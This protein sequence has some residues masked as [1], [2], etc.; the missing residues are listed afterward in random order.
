MLRRVSVLV[1]CATLAA[2]YAHAVPPQDLKLAEVK[3]WGLADGLPEESISCITESPDG[4]I[5][6]ATREGLVRFNGQ[7]F[8]Q[9]SPGQAAGQYD[10][11]LGAV[12]ATADVLWAGGRDY[13]GFALADDYRSFTRLKFKSTPFPRAGS[14][15]YGVVTMQS[16]PDG[17]VLL[18]RS[19]GV[20]SV[21]GR[22]HGGS[23][24]PQLIAAPPHGES[25]LGYREGRSG[26]WAVTRSGLKRWN[27]REWLPLRPAPDAPSSILEARDGSL[28]IYSDAELVHISGN[29]TRTYKLT[30]SLIGQ[31]A[32]SLIEDRDGAIWAGS[33]GYA[34]RI[35]GGNVER[36]DLGAHLRNDDLV[37]T[38]FQA[39]DGSVWMGSRTGVLLRVDAPVFS[40]VGRE[41]GV[42]AASA[43]AVQQDRTGRMWIGTRT[44]G[45]FVQAGDRWNKLPGSEERI[46]HAIAPLRDG[47]VMGADSNGLWVSNGTVLTELFNRPDRALGGFRALSA[48]YGDHI[49]ISDPAGVYR[50]P[51][52]TGSPIR[53][54]SSVGATR[55]LTELEDGVWGVSWDRGVFRIRDGV[56][57]EYPLRDISAS[58]GMTLLSL[59]PR[60]FLIGT[61]N[62]VFGFDRTT[63]T[64]IKAKTLLAG[65]QVFFIQEDGDG[66]LWFAGRRSLVWAAKTAVAAWFEGTGGPVPPTRLT[67]SQGLASTNYGLGTSSVAMLASDGQLWL[68]SQAG[69]IHFNPASV[70]SARPDVRCAI[71]EVLIDGAAVPL[72]GAI[73]VKPGAKRLQIRYTVLG[74]RAAENPAFRYRLQGEQT[75]LESSAFEAVYTNLRPGP[76]RFELQARVSS[77]EWPSAVATLDVEVEPHWYERP[78]VQFVLGFALLFTALCAIGTRHQRN[79]RQ[80]R[81][82]EEAVYAR[83]EELAR[84][85]ERAEELRIR[86]EAATRAKSEFLA[87]MSHE[88]RTPLNGVI[89]MTDLALATELSPSQREMLMVARVSADS[90]LTVINDVLDFSKIEAGKMLLAN[91]PFAIRT[92]IEDTVAI[93]RFSARKKGLEVFV[94][95]A[96]EIPQQLSGDPGR[97]RQ[98]LL[99]LLA[100]AVKFTN[101]GSIRVTAGLDESAV[102]R[103]LLRFSVRDTGIGIPQE[104]HQQIFRPFE[105]ADAS[106]TRRYGGTGLGLA[107]SSRL[108][109]LMQGSMWVES[110]PGRGSAFSF[111]AAFTIAACRTEEP[112]PVTNARRVLTVRRDRPARILLAEDNAVNQLV[113]VKLLKS[114]DY[115]VSVAHTGREAVEAWENDQFDLLLLDVQMPD[116]DGVEATLEIRRREGH[117]RHVP[118][119]ALTAGAFAEDRSRCLAAGMDDFVPKPIVPG[120]LLAVI[121]RW[122]PA[123]VACPVHLTTDFATQP[124]ALR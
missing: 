53:R 3:S 115:D 111:T 77:L 47:R 117:D 28:W 24:Q 11:G 88:I 27:G 6:L 15:R 101:S 41:E 33:V 45:V 112:G 118:I 94:S 74:R 119:V 43:A 44:A 32:N 100:N 51:L 1:W 23:I 107:I 68:A 75:W 114:W 83:T 37:Q 17:G 72:D 55:A 40:V 57:T 49:Y 52:P 8:R 78:W 38:V 39:H 12:A 95:I 116:M 61:N 85:T 92:L 84:A 4:Y 123:E 102:D 86:A 22:T 108:V 9:Y 99:N 120:D 64:F 13:I 124:P 50:V 46:T 20:Y 25:F 71:E 7:S 80:T 66:K 98:V 96:D 26:R 97:L 76:L 48:D 30:T 67:A 59:T 104:L 93:V 58:R 79:Q 81:L 29:T 113:A 106:D 70:T 14:D 87:N 19:D 109:Q 10:N 110:E 91:E 69:A 34:L 56:T 63:G 90:L 54:I 5:W 103:A 89:G 16:Q 18:W 42:Q 73:H 2:V 21:A 122:V 62:G 36:L 105:Q 60:I 121:E 31:P 35:R 82:L 65:E